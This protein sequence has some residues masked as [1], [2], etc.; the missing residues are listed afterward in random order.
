[1]S[2]L[3]KGDS[4]IELAKLKDYSVDLI[5]TDPP[6]GYSFM[7]KDWDK[8]VPS[9]ELW[10]E[11]LRVLQPGGF[12]FIMSAPRSDVHSEMV[13]RL[14]QSG[15]KFDWVGFSDIDKYPKN[16][17]KKSCSISVFVKNLF[18]F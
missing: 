4:L 5:V 9:V 6:Y 8:A 2:E 13:K 7:G 15:F 18:R 1:M 17:D 16:L 14:E 10:K 12:A 3:I 11:C